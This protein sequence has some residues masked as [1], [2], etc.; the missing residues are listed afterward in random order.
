M[1]LLAFTLALGMLG[2]DEAANTPPPGFT[3]LFNGKDLTNWK[4]EG[5]ARGHW[6]VV[7]GVLHYD[8]QGDSLVTSRDYGDFELYVD[9]KIGPKADS[10]IYLRGKPQVQIW[11]NPVGSGGLYNNKANP[12]RPLK[13]ADRPVGE[14]NTFHIL[15]RGD[16]VTVF[17]NGEK[18]VDDVPLE[19]WPDYKDPLPA[20]GTIELQHHGNPLEF[21]N[22]YIKEL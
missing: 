1:T 18:V 5:K 10:G 17:L 13:V 16:R 15:M 21:R 11:D 20:R 12:S 3:A 7:N 9:W 2:A 8:G 19:N 22:I 14:W 6:T 4:D